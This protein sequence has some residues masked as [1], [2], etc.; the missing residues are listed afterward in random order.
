MSAIAETLAPRRMSS[1]QTGADDAASA[2]TT[3][4]RATAL[5][6]CVYA[7]FNMA[8][9]AACLFVL[10][11][12][13]RPTFPPSCTDTLFFRAFGLPDGFRPCIIMG[14]GLFPGEGAERLLAGRGKFAKA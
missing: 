9:M 3:S 1:T 13:R 10:F 12:R 4:T 2:A 11:F 7:L 5:A 8:V 6:P 14:M